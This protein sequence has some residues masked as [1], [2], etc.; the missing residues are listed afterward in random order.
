MVWEP[1]S[2]NQDVCLYCLCCFYK[3]STVKPM[4]K[5]FLSIQV[6]LS[7]PYSRT[8]QQIISIEYIKSRDVYSSMKAI[9]RII[10]LTL[11][12]QPS[13]HAKINWGPLLGFAEARYQG[14]IWENHLVH[15]HFLTI[16]IWVTFKYLRYIALDLRLIWNWISQT[17]WNFSLNVYT[18][19]WTKT[20]LC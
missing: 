13:L 7:I 4:I 19:I 9:W 10:S 14:L 12:M 8:L 15:I 6:C 16:Y 20:T 2:H 3:L 1:R 11:L 17:Q 5:V 18:L